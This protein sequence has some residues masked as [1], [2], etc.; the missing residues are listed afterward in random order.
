MYSKYCPKNDNYALMEAALKAIDGIDQDTANAIIRLHQTVYKPQFESV[1]SVV[2]LSLSS[3]LIGTA[4]RSS[5][6]G[7]IAKI[8]AAAGGASIPFIGWAAAV[9]MVG[10]AIY[11]V[12][13]S[14][15][16]VS[17][18][19]KDIAQEEDAV[20]TAKAAVEEQ[21]SKNPF[22]KYAMSAADRTSEI[23]MTAGG[24]LMDKLDAVAKTTSVNKADSVH[25][26]DDDAFA[27]KFG[28]TKD[29]TIVDAKTALN[30]SKQFFYYMNGMNEFGNKVIDKEAYAEY[31]KGFEEYWEQN[32]DFLPYFDEE[33]AKAKML[34]QYT[35]QYYKEQFLPMFSKKLKEASAYAEK[36]MSVEDLEAEGRN[37]FGD[38]VDKDKYYASMGFTKNAEITDM[39][40]FAKAF[41]YKTGLDL[42]Y[43]PLTPEGKALLERMLKNPSDEYLKYLPAPVF[44][45]TKEDQKPFIEKARD[46]HRRGESQVGRYGNE[47]M[48]AGAASY[49]AG[50]EGQVSNVTRQQVPNRQ[51]ASAQNAAKND[52]TNAPDVDKNAGPW[53]TVGKELLSSLYHTGNDRHK[54]LMRLGYILNIENGKYYRMSDAD[55]QTMHQIIMEDLDNVAHK[56]AEERRQ[57]NLRQGRLT[58]AQMT[59]DEIAESNRRAGFPADA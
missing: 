59:E 9:V 14:T 38:V 45:M 36:N 16:K 43:N 42:S 26:T 25:T 55:K 40:K 6:C 46:P 37:E 56:H 48:G 30:H 8:A 23:L 35:E 57:V 24:S 32:R 27:E 47:M 41:A 3:V 28:F 31:L 12:A 44:L 22:A 15:S 4:L 10:L 7:L 17:K 34:K 29:L 20:Q 49:N 13:T 33:G 19:M 52:I 21:M 58:R 51:N 39:N 2:G 54:H 18:E 50:A 53:R 1:G 5:V 11:D